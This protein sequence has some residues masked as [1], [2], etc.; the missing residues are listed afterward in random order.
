MFSTAFRIASDM[1]RRAKRR[2]EV[3]AASAMYAG[4]AG[5]LDDLDAPLRL[6]LDMPTGLA[7]VGGLPKN[8]DD[9]VVPPLQ[10]LTH[11][12][13]WL[14]AVVGHGF[15]GGVLDGLAVYY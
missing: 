15:H 2:R 13:D 4:W 1:R 3:E 5:R 7:P 9:L 8:L 6:A 11:D 12:G 14:E 10:S